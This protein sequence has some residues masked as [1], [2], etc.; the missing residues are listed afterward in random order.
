MGHTWSK[1][2]W[3]LPIFAAPAASV[4][5]RTRFV[6]SRLSS[7]RRSARVRHRKNRQ[8]LSRLA[9]GVAGLGEPARAARQGRRRAGDEIVRPSPPRE[10]AVRRFPVLTLRTRSF[11]CCKGL[12]AHPRVPADC[13]DHMGH[14]SEIIPR[15]SAPDFGFCGNLLPRLASEFD[16]SQYAVLR[17]YMHMLTFIIIFLN[18][19]YCSTSST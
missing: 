19:L 1:A 8:P 15:S 18:I 13:P 14:A 4:V 11:P 7:G 10:A 5:V 2:R 9:P 6:Q 3:Y 16:S 17:A 12:G